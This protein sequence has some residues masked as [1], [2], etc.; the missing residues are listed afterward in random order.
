ML[1][2]EHGPWWAA[3]K[4]AVC[5]CIEKQAKIDAALELIANLRKDTEDDVGLLAVRHALEPPPPSP[6]GCPHCGS[7]DAR[8]GKCQSCG[9]H[10]GML[11]MPGGDR[12]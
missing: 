6:R 2:K 3:T 9:Y 5:L 8:D 1:C 4:C 11:S 7:T 12:L 10:D